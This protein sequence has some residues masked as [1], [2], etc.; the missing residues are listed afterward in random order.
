MQSGHLGVDPPGW[1]AESAS[2]ER[3]R[4]ATG[5]DSRAFADGIGDL[6]LNF[7]YRVFVNQRAR[8][9][10]FVQAITQT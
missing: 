5:N 8:S 9:N 6:F 2:P 4:L 10:A 1:S 7:K 3:V